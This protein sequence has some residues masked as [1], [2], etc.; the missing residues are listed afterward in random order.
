MDSWG[1]AM[2]HG[3]SLKACLGQLCLGAIVYHLWKQRNDLPHFH[4]PRTEEAIFD[5]IKLDVQVCVLAQSRFK[6]LN[7]NVE[8]VDKWNLHPIWH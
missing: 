1:N 5:Q 4:T 2:Q 7:M 6:K 3:K 8:L